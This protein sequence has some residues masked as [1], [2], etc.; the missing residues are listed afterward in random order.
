MLPNMP[1]QNTCPSQGVVLKSIF[2]TLVVARVLICIKR[3]GKKIATSRLLE[4]CVSLAPILYAQ[5]LCYN[6]TNLI[7]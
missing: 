6:I 1:T 5:T 3:E 4:S 7:S 2:S